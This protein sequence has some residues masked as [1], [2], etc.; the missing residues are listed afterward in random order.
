[1]SRSFRLDC[2]G[3][4]AVEFALT[5]PFLLIL[6]LGVIE[7]SAAVRA[8]L[9]IGHVARY[10]AGILE[11]QTSVSEAQ[12]QDYVYAAQDMYGSGGADGTLVLSAE[13]VNFTNEDSQ[14]NYENGGYCIGWDASGDGGSTPAAYAKLATAF[15]NAANN[16]GNLTDGLD[17]DSTIIVAAKAVYSLPFI[18]SFYGKISNSFTLS[19]IAR[20]RP[21]YVL[22]IP[23]N[24]TGGFAS[25]C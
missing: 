15:P 24:P 8:Q 2:R 10:V 19:A 11:N 13:S 7:F 25:S 21:R 18:P 12:L 1:M 4:A 20:V 9:E 22:Q 6:A 3:N 17:N 5:V 14:G 16:V 23:T